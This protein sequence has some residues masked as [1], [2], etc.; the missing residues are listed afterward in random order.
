MNAWLNKQI[1]LETGEREQASLEQLE[2]ALE[3]VPD[4]V[5]AIAKL[6][7]DKLKEVRKGG[8]L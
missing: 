6:V 3:R 5:D 8:K 1:N 4:A 7:D 2:L